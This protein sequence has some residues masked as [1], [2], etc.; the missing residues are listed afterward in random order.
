MLNYSI[1]KSIIDDKIILKIGIKM[2]NPMENMRSL[3]DDMRS[4]NRHI[5]ASLFSYNGREYIVIY[6]DLENI[7]KNIYYLF[8][9]TFRDTEDGR[10]LSCNA[11]TKSMDIKISTLKNYFYVYSGERYTDWI[12][13]FYK[14]FGSN[15]PLYINENF[16]KKE[17]E[18]MIDILNIR[19]DCNNGIY[20][21]GV[22]RNPIINGRQLKRSPYNTD[23][24]IL[25]RPDLFERL[26]G[27]EN[28]S[29]MYSSDLSK[30][31]DTTQILIDFAKKE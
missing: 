27:D 2:P 31:K 21:F 14:Y 13:T 23:K 6:E 19:D 28:I 9:L 3:R 16:T 15:I 1:D 20:C 24:T 8:K 17:K 5:T 26:G 4:K 18:A 22:K 7:E 29:F 25:L 30:E 12:G 11:N 10:E